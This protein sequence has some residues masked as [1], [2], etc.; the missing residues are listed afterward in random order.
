ME[1]P[2]YI[3]ASPTRM[4]LL[5]MYPEGSVVCREDV[6]NAYILLSPSMTRIN[7]N[8]GNGTKK[9]MS[10]PSS[11][12]WRGIRFFKEMVSKGHWTAK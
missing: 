2:V 1:L 4:K 10:I 6:G 5:E 3:K 11:R 8:R 12:R 9:R 7:K